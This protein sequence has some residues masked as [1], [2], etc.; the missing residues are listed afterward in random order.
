VYNLCGTRSRPRRKARAAAAKEAAEATPVNLKTKWSNS[1]VR[2]TSRGGVSHWQGCFSKTRANR[3]L[4]TCAKNCSRWRMQV[5]S[6]YS[7]RA[8]FSSFMAS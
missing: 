1:G 8:S 4:W 2:I 7:L 3:R 6:K 5:L